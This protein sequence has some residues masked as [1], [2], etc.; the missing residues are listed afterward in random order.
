MAFVSSNTT[1]SSCCGDKAGPLLAWLAKHEREAQCVWLA[2]WELGAEGASALAAALQ[3]NESMCELGLGRGCGVAH[4][5]AK[6][7][8]GDAGLDEDAAKARGTASG[9]NIGSATDG[10]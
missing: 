5:G 6:A 8:A 4:G 1:S 10:A 3:S 2:D 9:H 7:L